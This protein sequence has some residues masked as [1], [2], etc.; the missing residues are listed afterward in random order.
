MVSNSI[1]EGNDQFNL[2]EF[3]V[4]RILSNT[5]KP[6]KQVAKKTSKTSSRASIGREKSEDELDTA[7]ETQV[8]GTCYDS[9]VSTHDSMGLK[10]LKSTMFCDFP[11]FESGSE[12]T[13][14]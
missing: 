7:H 4:F 6:Q 3:Y 2:L 5:Q 14:I 1:R 12:Q 13:C 8:A 11:S 10:R 9:A